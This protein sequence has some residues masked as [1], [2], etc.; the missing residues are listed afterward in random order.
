MTIAG[1]E[2]CYRTTKSIRREN[3]TESEE[4]VAMKLP[5]PSCI[6]P[7]R[8]NIVVVAS[9]SGK[10]GPLW[11]ARRAAESTKDKENQFD[12]VKRTQSICDCARARLGV[13]VVGGQPEDLWSWSAGSKLTD[14]GEL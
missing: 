3:G 9:L 11:T 2:L 12:R 4:K 14:G 8:I 1:S 5:T 10:Q 7:S 13:V 6:G